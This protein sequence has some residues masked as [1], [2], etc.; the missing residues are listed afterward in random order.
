MS[1]INRPKTP[2]CVMVGKANLM[3][4][5]VLPHLIKNY[6]IPLGEHK[7]E[8]AFFALSGDIKNN[9]YLKKDFENDLNSLIEYCENNAITYIVV[10]DAKFWQ[11]ATKDKNYMMHMEKGNILNG[12]GRLERFTIIPVLSYFM[13]LP[14]PQ[15][16]PVLDASLITLKNVLNGTYSKTELIIDKVNV[17]VIDTIDGV[18]ELFQLLP[19]I[20][21][22]TMD[23]ETTGLRVGID[24]IITLAF[25]DSETNG[26]AIPLCME[27]WFEIITKDI[28]KYS[29]E[30]FEAINFES[31]KDSFIDLNGF[32]DTYSEITEDSKEFSNFVLDKYKSKE[33][34]N[35]KYVDN[36]F[37]FLEE[38]QILNEETRSLT[39][40]FFENYSGEQ[41]WHNHGFDLP[42]IIRDICEVEP[43]D[44]SKINKLI[45]SWTIT[46]TMILKFLCVNGLDRTSLGLKEFILPLYGEYDKNIDQTKL[47]EYSYYDVGKYNVY[48][49]TA[50]YEMYNKYSALIH[51]EEQYDILKE[52]YEPSMKTLLKVKC[53]GLVVNLDK[54]TKADDK[55][56]AEVKN[57]N[58]ILQNNSYVQE[59]QEDL[60]F[61]AMLK[62]NN[63]HVKQKSIDDFEVTFNPNSVA[64][65]KML[66]IDILGYPV[67]ETTKTGNPSLGKDVIKAYKQGEKD[68]EK[69]EILNAIT[70]ISNAAKVSGTFFKS[71]RTMSVPAPDGT[72][73][74]HADFKLTG[75]VSG[76]L[77]SA[78]PNLQNLPS[79]SVLGKV[80][81]ETCDAPEGFIW[82]SSDYSSLEDFIIAEYTEDEVKKKILLDGYDSHSLYLASYIPEKLKELGLPYGDITKE[83]S[84]IIK[85]DPIGKK[86]RDGHKAVTFALAYNGT[87]HTVAKALGIS[88]EEAKV[89]VDNYA[90]LHWRI[91]QK[92]KE[93]AEEA[94]EVGYGITPF[95]LKIR[96]SQLQSSDETVAS[97]AMRSLTNAIYQGPAGMLTVKAM[98]KIQKRIEE[99]GYDD[100]VILFNTIHDAIYAYVRHDYKILKWYNDNLIECMTEDYKENQVLK[101][102]AN[103]DVGYHWADQRE[104]PNNCSEQEIREILNSKE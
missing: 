6:L 42:F 103:L 68:E 23:I 35:F 84:F 95:G 19:N 86:L 76:R 75:T 10:T 51:E 2:R 81:K 18:R 99:A 1:V 30:D 29:L 47:L 58:N 16:R 26:W 79:G 55:L 63:T 62:Y 15:K 36:H 88:L 4:P 52:Y 72:H 96:S 71:F 38:S 90:K 100:D 53:R 49:T 59:V 54:V 21:R 69:L 7:D 74:L 64:H 93:I 14:Q 94:K 20:P 73:R 70:E 9:K 31:L 24:R 61:D 25:A 98:N 60:A 50:T 48:D 12:V 85:N 102:K 39:K 17:N 66:L 33:Y 89:I 92:Q 45:N 57:Q 40:E 11:F 56:I 101:L 91:K 8:V 27:Y 78:N 104:L 46:D 67:L 32:E 44:Y 5:K 28:E 97:Q 41:V 22:L 34:G 43:I 3:S 65:K 77:S 83:E 80:L 87:E 13:L 82:T 37:N